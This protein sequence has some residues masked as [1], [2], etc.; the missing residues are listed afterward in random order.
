VGTPDAGAFWRVV[1]E[2]GVK[3]LLTAPTAMRAIKK[4][5]PHAELMAGY[6]MTR[7]RCLF[8]AGERLDPDTYTW[9]RTVLGVPVIDNWWQTETG[10]PIAANPRGLEPMPVKPGSPSV[11]MPGYDLRILDAEGHDR[12]AGEEGAIALRLPLPPGT[13]TTLWGDD[14][15]YVDSYLSQYPGY[16]LTGD[17]GY[18]DIAVLFGPM[19]G[20]TMYAGE[21]VVAG[22]PGVAGAIRR[23]GNLALT[24]SEGGLILF[25]HGNGKGFYGLREEV[26]LYSNDSPFVEQRFALSLLISKDEVDAKIQR[27]YLQLFAICAALVLIGGA[28]SIFIGR[29]YLNPIMS[30][31]DVIRSGKLDGVKT[32]I[33]EIDQIIA[34]IRDQKGMDKPFPDD[35]FNDYKRRIK[36]LTPVEK[37]IFGYYLMD[38]DQKKILSA[39]FITKNAVRIHNER[40]YSKLGVSGRKAFM[41]YIELVKMSGFTDKVA[42]G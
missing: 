40:I 18:R 42:S 5:D 33:V 38:M 37:N 2:H 3:A 27:D 9:A 36:T 32:N 16:Y 31:L 21:F 10:W 29:R 17:G 41:L 28:V 15:R 19:S 23:D 34:Q 35:F 12:P 24:T 25:E 30:A 8:L 7:F 1:A 11:P 20:N 13:L 14:D 4:L 26:R 22:R 39:L 6:D